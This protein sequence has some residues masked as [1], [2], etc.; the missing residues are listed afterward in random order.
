MFYHV[1]VGVTKASQKRCW[2]CKGASHVP[3]L[4]MTLVNEECSGRLTKEPSTN[5]SNITKLVRIFSL[6]EVA[7]MVSMRSG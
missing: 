4:S 5:A 7:G 3:D 1:G 2:D 6:V